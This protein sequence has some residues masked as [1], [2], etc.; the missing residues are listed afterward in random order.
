MSGT[1][2]LQFARGNTTDGFWGKAAHE[3]PADSPFG[4][5]RGWRRTTNHAIRRR[6]MDPV[7][8]QRAPGG[9]LI[10]KPDKTQLLKGPMDLVIERSP[11]TGNGGAT[12]ARGVNYEAYAHIDTITFRHGSN[13][14][15]E[16]TGD[17]LYLDFARLVK[18][19]IKEMENELV[20]GNKSI[21]ER[22]VL[23]ANPK[24]W[25]IN[26][27]H[28]IPFMK[29]PSRY[30]PIPA[31]AH[32]IEILIKFKKAEFV[33]QT[34]G[35]A[36]PT[37][38]INRCFLRSMDVHLMPDEKEKIMKQALSGIDFRVTDWETQRDFLDPAVG[39]TRY[40]IQVTNFKHSSNEMIFILRR[41]ADLAGVVPNP[42]QSNTNFQDLAKYQMTAGTVQVWDETESEYARFRLNPLYHSAQGGEL[43]FIVYFGLDVESDHNVAGHKTFASFNNCKLIIDFAAPL[44]QQLVL[45]MFNC[46]NNIWQL[47]GGEI[48]RIFF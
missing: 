48:K 23:A 27:A 17:E 10:F 6:D 32:E 33:T 38:T 11:I 47:Q 30:L 40:E 20:G 45:D 25:Y 4:N 44:G 42:T 41:A 31:I 37:Y 7:S 5:Y 3:S 21:A 24:R 13:T 19:D 29:N 28:S 22:N 12:F 26:L 14:F 46:Y 9:T 15:Y 43:I 34:D 8:G 18:W 39:K 1:E 35:T 36:A 2:L 16:I